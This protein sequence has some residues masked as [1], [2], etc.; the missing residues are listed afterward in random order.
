MQIARQLDLMFDAEPP[1]ILRMTTEHPSIRKAQE[2]LAE[3]QSDGIRDLIRNWLA[4][5]PGDRLPGRQHFDPLAI[6]RLLKNVILTEVERDPY[7]FRVRVVG[8]VIA[9]AFGRDFTGKYMD[10]VFEGHA[11]SLSHSVRVEVVETGMP[12]LRPAA[13]GTFKGMDIAPLE[14]V[15]LPLA[16]DGV[17]VDHVLS[18]FVYLPKTADGSGGVWFISNR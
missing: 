18:M 7:R 15:H 3:A 5:H 1:R 13:P 17:T 4:I 9:D 11:E 10:E 16:A 2:L 8:T 12:H 14:G 6:P